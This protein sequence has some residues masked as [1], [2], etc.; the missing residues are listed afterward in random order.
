MRIK[1]RRTGA[2][3]IPVIG[4]VNALWLAEESQHARV[5]AAVA[6]KY[7]DT[8][9]HLSHG[10]FSRDRRS[11]L[12]APGLRVAS[13]YPRGILAA[14]LTLGSMQEYVAL[15]TYNAL[16]THGLPATVTALLRQISR[17]EDRHVRFYRM[18]AEAVLSGDSRTQ[19]FTRTLIDRFWPAGDRLVRPSRLVRDPRTINRGSGS[20][21][22]D[23]SRG[24][25]DFRA[26]RLSINTGHG[27]ILANGDGRY[28]R[29]CVDLWRAA[30]FL[31][32]PCSP[33][34]RIGIGTA[35]R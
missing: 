11:I 14:Y 18:G 4:Q 1:L 24:Q 15:T 20:P 6:G 34:S 7:G 21:S 25:V 5:L 13:I 12:T 17:Q 22:A 32:S 28:D 23:A 19:W 2:D 31:E 16:A 9:D 35:S 30:T 3:R 33:L 26:A 10:V 27:P 8:P 29:R